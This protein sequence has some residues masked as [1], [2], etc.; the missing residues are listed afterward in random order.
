MV[1]LNEV[2][3]NRDELLAQTFLVL[4]DFLTRNGIAVLRY[5]DRGT[6]QSKGD[7]KSATSTD[8]AADVEAIEY[9]KQKKNR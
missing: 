7:F 2:I 8:F 6:A 9:L 4:S 5:D 3:Q 1:I